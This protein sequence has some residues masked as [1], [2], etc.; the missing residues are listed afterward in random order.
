MSILKPVAGIAILALLISCAATSTLK[1]PPTR[2]GQ[3][4]DTYHGVQV[5]DPY[6]WLEDDNSPETKAW[7]EA[8]NKVTFSFL[9]TIP[10]RA[11]IKTR[12]TTLWPQV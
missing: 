6:R 5:A 4:T 10:E 3:Q 7:V 2:K 11:A 1:Y 12:L 9:G 8:E